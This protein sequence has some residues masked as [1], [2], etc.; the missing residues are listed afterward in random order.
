[1]SLNKTQYVV[2]TLD[3]LD[4]K[5]NCQRR[6]RIGKNKDMEIYKHDLECVIELKDGSSVPLK[7]K[8]GNEDLM[9][10]NNTGVSIETLTTATHVSNVTIQDL[11]IELGNG[12]TGDPSDDDPEQNP[13]G[14]SGIVM[15]RGDTGED[16][17]FMGFD[18]SENK[19]IMGTGTFTGA[20]SGNLTVSPGTLQ[21]AEIEGPTALTLT[22]TSGTMT[23]NGNG[24]TIDVN[25]ED[26]DID[27]T[28]DISLDAGAASNF[29]TSEGALTLDGASGV[30][31]QG[32]NSEIDV[33]TTGD[34]DLNSG[35]FTLNCSTTTITST[36]T[37]SLIMETN[38]ADA[39][40]LT[41][42][43]SN[44]GGGNASINIGTTEST[45]ISIGHT[46]S[47]TTVND[48]LNVAGDTSVSTFDSSGATSLA[49]GGGSVNIASTGAMTTI[50][51]T[52]NVD[53]AVSFDSTLDITSDTDGEFVALKLVNESDASDTTGIV[54]LEFDLEDTDGNAVDAGKIAVK[55]NE[56]FTPTAS[57]QDSNMVFSTSLNGTLTEHLSL[58]SD[59]TLTTKHIL[60]NTHNT[61]DLGSDTIRFQD[62][63][64][65]K[66]LNVSNTLADSLTTR[67]IIEISSF[68]DA[69]NDATSAG[70]LKFQKSANDNLNTYTQT[71]SG[72]VLGRIEA[73]GVNTDNTTTL[74]SYIEF[75]NDADSNVNSVPG[76]IAFA[77]SDADDAGNPTVRM[78]I[79]NEGTVS[80]T[81]FSANTIQSS[82]NNNLVIQADNAIQMETDSIIM[83][84]S[85]SNNPLVLIK[86][87]F[88]DANPPRLT[89]LKERA[90]PADGDECGAF[91][92]SA[93]D[94]NNN[95]TRFA[96]IKGI[97][98]VVT[99]GSERGQ[100]SLSVSENDGNLTSGLTLS[101]STTDGQVDVSIG[102]GSNSTTTITGTVDCGAIGCGV[103]TIN[104]TDDSNSLV[105]TSSGNTSDFF[106]VEVDANGATTLS[107]T[108]SSSDPQQ[109]DLTVSADGSI[110]LNSWANSVKL[111]STL[112]TNYG[113]FAGDSN[114]KLLIKNNGSTAITVNDTNI[115]IAGTVGCGAI[116]STGNMT[117]YN[118][119]NNADTSLSIGTGE[120]EALVI[121]VLNVDGTTTAEEIKFI[122]KTESTGANHG[123]MTFSVDESD[124][125][126]IN[127]NGIDV[128]TGSI[129]G[130]LATAAQTNITSVGTLTGLTVS[131]NVNATTLQIDGTALKLDHLSDA[132][133][134]NSSLYLGNIP[135]GLSGTPT[136]NTIIG[137]DSG[138]SLT[139]GNSNT[140]VG[141]GSGSSN[142]TGSLNS[143]LGTLSGMIQKE[144][145][146]IESAHASDDTTT[147]I[148]L[149]SSS[150]GTDDHY[151]NMY[152]MITGGS[153]SGEVRKI[154][155][156]DGTTK[157][158]TIDTAFN[159]DVDNTSTYIIYNVTEV[160]GSNLICIGAG[161]GPSAVDATNEITL[162]N[163]NV[164]TLRCATSTIASTSDR[165][166]KKEINDSVFGLDF[167]KKVRP[168]EFT[169]AKRQGGESINGMRRLGFI[170]QELQEAMPNGENEILDLVYD[171][172]PEY[173]EAKY[174]NLVPIL[175]KS[176]QEL[177][178]KSAV[179]E[180]KSAVLEE[181]NKQ[182]KE[183]LSKLE[184]LVNKLL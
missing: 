133:Y 82:A 131:G 134:D 81:K 32:N 171:S 52:L 54:S 175:T 80:A 76:K 86:N 15:I 125:L 130:T 179:L 97:A 104:G 50:K 45:A 117:I 23:I 41:I 169:W 157:V 123:K 106:A 180:E 95:E 89:M 144:T 90:A 43:A 108:D 55:K 147:E 162:G 66:E 94:S 51:G 11:L 93:R 140:L 178:E 135:S 74:S 2:D 110:N 160:T 109:A 83:T 114:N 107:T 91:A 103:L 87:T 122:S 9:T 92:F 69:N 39:K 163:S 141:S 101:G 102:A 146:T 124:I 119:Q 182:L 132:Q 168:V 67:P 148:T 40:T 137:N 136:H 165:R 128:I 174:G 61:Y 88:D 68:S 149:A 138:E 98:T 143:F 1:M 44:N 73:Y 13:S 172:N 121:Q 64:L 70:V 112:G 35:P 58:G 10:L 7:F 57:T 139:T 42:D 145:G 170:A 33:T 111:A 79:D 105:V 78:T 14:D 47:E 46:T 77:I 127:D 19:F 63:Y 22:S 62:L 18:D 53:E 142:T 5:D 29:T 49:T 72:E 3:L 4:D 99:D 167:I 118:N 159:T 100:L 36:N 151:N 116:S 60:P 154:T 115:T 126:E 26:I 8:N 25:C 65:S 113:E 71:N 59:G 156:Y 177:A 48:N 30:N 166:D 153:G 84:S 96:E 75:A 85:N 129:T 152:I 181:E 38:S 6:I 37:T 20:T 176:V 164:D 12:R 158:A 183:R 56:V 21:V 16:N 173:L 34:L 161:A 17:A 155:D 24:Q 184:A 150:N 27:T 120:D 31:I 28:N